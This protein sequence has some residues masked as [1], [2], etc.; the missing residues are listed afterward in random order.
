MSNTYLDPYD[1]ER[2]PHSARAETGSIVDMDDRS[3]WS[4]GQRLLAEWFEAHETEG[5]VP[6]DTPIDLLGP[7]LGYVHKL[8]YDRDENDFR[9]LIYG[10]S[11]AKKSNMGGDGTRVSDLIEPTR[12]VFLE[13]YR[14]LVANPR[15]SVGRLTYQGTNVPNNEWIRAVAPLGRPGDGVTHFIVFTETVQDARF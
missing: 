2:E 13:H 4:Y 10:R 5:L 14:A 15:L 8:A 7:V 1:S 12:S 11:I 3:A 6:P 9:Y